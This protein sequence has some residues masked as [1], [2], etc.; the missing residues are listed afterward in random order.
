[1]EH[2]VGGE[3][4]SGNCHVELTKPSQWCS[5]DIGCFGPYI[6]KTSSKVYIVQVLIVFNQGA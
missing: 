3:G 5:L 1:M 6:V 2:L 4:G